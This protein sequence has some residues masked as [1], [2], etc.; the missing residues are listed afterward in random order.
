MAD[1]FAFLAVLN[2]SKVQLCLVLMFALVAAFWRYSPLMPKVFYGDDLGF[3]LAFKDG[4]CG[5]VVSQILTTVCADK[6]RPVAAGFI[7]LLFNLFDSTIAHYMTVN[8]LLQA[9]SAT[10]VF[11]IAHRLSNGNL[12]V[13]LCIAIAVATSRFA[14]YQ[15]TQVIG[16][17]EGLALPLF[18]AVVYS[19]LRADEQQ[20]DTWR[21][22]WTAILLSFLL[23]HNHER[24]ILISAWLG[25]AFILLPN[26]RA[27]PEKYFVALLAASV[28][29]PV[30]YVAYKIAVLHT[31]FL[32][33]TGG[34]Y[35]DFD[36]G[37]MLKHLRQAVLSIFGFN[38]GPE[39]LIGVKL[40]SLPW[41]PAWILASIFFIT[42]VL[43]IFLG[44]RSALIHQA[45]S[46]SIL[47]RL[48]SIRWPI[49]FFV[50]SLLLLLPAISTIRVEQ[51]WLF[52]PFILLLLA[53]A[54]AVSQ[55]QSKFRIP[56]WPLIVVLSV[57]SI[58][59]DRAILK[60]FNNVFFVY[61]PRFA[62]M[63]KRDI[64]D[65]YSG[66]SW[67]IDLLAVKS[68]CD[69]SLWNGGFFRI[70]GGQQRQV[71]CIST[72]DISGDIAP[73]SRARVFAERSPGYLSDITDE[74][75]KRPQAEH[76]KF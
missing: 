4:E 25:I 39:N 40:R 12:V 75:R 7:L 62:E 54:W 22:G 73:D 18:L 17:V 38:S 71:K 68:H 23:I 67:D 19:L 59:L 56:G 74:W 6:F 1:R 20:E 52:A 45:K 50:L 5:T 58:L 65:K 43:I 35:L 33:G 61:S 29:L 13:A 60:H 16:P 44:V 72:N 57:S 14:A 49:L 27:L 76:N 48:S 37:R 53:G 46:I 32:V 9:I 31:P 8:V 24:Y 64:A 63:V 34:S 69:W 47:I 28:A 55:Q 42:I 41:F 3:F 51:R 66:Q 15:V 30:F 26:F 70:Y 2:N 21:F 36:P 10:L 11:A